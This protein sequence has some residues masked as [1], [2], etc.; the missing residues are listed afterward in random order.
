[1]KTKGLADDHVKVR[2]TP[3][4][5]VMDWLRQRCH[6]GDQLVSNLLVSTDS[7]GKVG[8]SNS[9]GITSCND[10]PLS[11]I[12]DL[13]RSKATLLGVKQFGKQRLLRV[14]GIFGDHFIVS[15]DG[16]ARI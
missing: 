13:F 4:V 8:Q 6:L 2:Q 7:V 15:V 11:L 12:L 10:V 14:G 9:S 3:K 16:L 5:V 1:M